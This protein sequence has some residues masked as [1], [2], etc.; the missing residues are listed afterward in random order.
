MRAN[1]LP[2]LDR[3]QTFPKMAV[4]VGWAGPGEPSAAYAGRALLRLCLRREDEIAKEFIIR[5]RARKPD[6]IT[7]GAIMRYLPELKPSRVDALADHLRGLASDL[8]GQLRSF[9]TEEI[10]KLGGHWEAR[11]T[12][13]ERQLK[14]LGRTHART[15][16]RRKRGRNRS[17]SEP[18]GTTRNHLEP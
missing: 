17:R 11:F 5:D 4:E 8:R 3:P 12:E 1:K 9:A 10:A 6:K 13:I 7:L 15:K 14:A 2:K 18:R 16:G